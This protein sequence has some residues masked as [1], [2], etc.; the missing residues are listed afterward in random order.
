MGSCPRP[1]D[2]GP[3]GRWSLGCGWGSLWRNV[4]ERVPVGD[5][6]TRLS[7][8]R[9]AGIRAQVEYDSAK[10]LLN[11]VNVDTHDAECS[12]EGRVSES[13]HETATLVAQPHTPV[14]EKSVLAFNRVTS[15]AV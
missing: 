3:Y 4:T 8:N 10:E 2:H 15:T 7:W 6:L 13:P 1:V 11:Q 14:L 5:S 12:H 9:V